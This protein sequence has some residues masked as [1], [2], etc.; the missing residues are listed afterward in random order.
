MLR[1]PRFSRVE[2]LGL[3]KSAKLGKTGA[4]SLA[5]VCPHLRELDL[6]SLAVSNDDCA[7]LHAAIPELAGLS[8]Y[9][10]YAQSSTLGHAVHPL[11]GY[12]M[13]ATAQRLCDAF[14]PFASLLRLQISC[15]H[16]EADDFG[17]LVL[18]QLAKHCPKI[19]LLSMVSTFLEDIPMHWSEEVMDREMRE[20]ARTQNLTDLGVAALLGGCP[21]LHSLTLKPAWFLETSFQ[22]ISDQLKASPPLLKLKHLAVTDNPALSSPVSGSLLRLSLATNQSAHV[23]MITV[24][25]R[26][27][28]T[29]PPWLRYG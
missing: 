8:F 23:G 13:R 19:E 12:L 21:Q 11:N 3:G 24:Y 10:D 4:A 28:L 14:S 22:T 17:D 26:T 18:R 1:Q 27:L 20:Q 25:T 15:T 6:T 16:R 29:L 9:V 5:K 7:S 2:V